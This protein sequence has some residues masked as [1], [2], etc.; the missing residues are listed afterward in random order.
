MDSGCQ[1][2]TVICVNK[3]CYETNCDTT[4]GC[5]YAAVVCDDENLCT[6]DSCTVVNGEASC[7]FTAI[8]CPNNDGCFPQICNVSSGRCET[9][10]VD[11]DDN[12][13]CTKDTCFNNLGLATCVYSP[14]NCTDHNP[15]TLDSCIPAVGCI[16]NTTDPAT[17]CDDNNVC[18]QDYCDSTIGCYH[19]ETSFTAPNLCETPY[20]DPI[21]GVGYTPKSCGKISECQ[22]D[23]TKGCVCNQPTQ[24]SLTTV[25]A[26]VSAGLAL[27]ILGIIAAIALIIY[28]GKKGYD[29]YRL[30]TRKANSVMDN[31]MYEAAQKE[32]FNPFYK[33]AN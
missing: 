11:C 25:A 14:T 21:R 29:Y 17:L 13:L 20:C 12:N 16:F 15:C 32:K 19:N 4:Y 28:T 7:S 6:V 9:N 1:F 26:A 30:D 24:A 18:T 5:E 23:P 31:P 2:T 33:D 8:L 22:C 3:P 27:L 10:P